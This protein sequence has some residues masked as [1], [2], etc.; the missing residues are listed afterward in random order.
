MERSGG[1]V[2]VLEQHRVHVVDRNRGELH[3]VR[4]EGHVLREEGWV[5]WVLMIELIGVG[6]DATGVGTEC[7]G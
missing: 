1:D 6:A 2:V 7:D 3:V 4:L 5:P